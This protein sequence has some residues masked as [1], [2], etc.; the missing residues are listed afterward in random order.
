MK[1]GCF[2]LVFIFIG[3][4]CNREQ[5]ENRFSIRCEFSNSR[6]E[7]ILLCEMGVKETIP[8]DSARIDNGK[9]NLFH[10]I[11]QPGFYLLIFPSG[12]RLTLVMKKGEDLF[13]TGD[14]TGPTS[15]FQLSGSPDSQLL[16]TFFRATMKNKNRIDSIKKVLLM[17]EGCDDFLRFSM[18]ADSLFSRIS[19]DQRKLEKEF[20]DQH[21]VSLASLIVLNFAFGP[22]PVLTMEED[23]PY[24][25]KLTSLFSFYPKNKH[26]LF[27]LARVN[28]F[29]NHSKNAK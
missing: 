26:V 19:G 25:L 13:I 18:M 21:L 15:D 14:I 4:S 20:I 11:E 23:L 10:K 22:K 17:H 5:K 29:L 27:H 8:L 2:I 9:I 16:Q 3:V 7:K 24:Y 28:L 12:K 6:S 1:A